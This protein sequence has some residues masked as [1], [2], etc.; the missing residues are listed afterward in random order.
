M[1]LV[2]RKILSR[3][4]FLLGHEGT[5]QAS[6]SLDQRLTITP[7]VDSL[8]NVLAGF[9]FVSVKEATTS[10]PTTLVKSSPHTD[11]G[12]DGNVSAQRHQSH[13]RRLTSTDLLIESYR[14]STA[15]RERE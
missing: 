8:F 13:R 5:P 14:L 2:S 10:A 6:D 11:D 1:F 4:V 12:D 3:C 9:V 7:F 15:V